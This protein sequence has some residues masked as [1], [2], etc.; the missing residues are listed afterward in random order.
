MSSSPSSK[1]SGLM[2]MQTPLLS[3]SP[4]STSIF[5][6]IAIPSP[7][8]L[9]GHVLPARDVLHGHS[10]APVPVHLVTRHEVDE[11]LQCD[12]AFEASQRRAEAAVNP[13]PEAEMLCL[14]LVALDVE[15]VGVGEGIAVAVRRR[16]AQEYRLEGGNHAAADMRL[17]QGVADV[18]LDRPLKAQ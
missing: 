18:V 16:A 8:H 10:L 13:I 4:Q 17:F 14:G 11:L 2:P 6:V 1:I 7:N 12:P 3:Q 9:D 5:F 15:G